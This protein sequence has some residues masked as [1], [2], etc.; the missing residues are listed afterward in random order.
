M[1]NAEEARQKNQQGEEK[2]FKR[3]PD[4]PQHYI[5]NK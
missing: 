1:F 4:T 3:K 2:Y 5:K